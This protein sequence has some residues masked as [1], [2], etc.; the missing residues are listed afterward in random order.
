[1]KSEQNPKVIEGIVLDTLL[2]FIKHE[3]G[4]FHNGVSYKES[5]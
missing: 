5:G 1:M 4:L 3:F 2:V